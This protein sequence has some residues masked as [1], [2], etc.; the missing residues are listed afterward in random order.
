MRNRRQPEYA[1]ATREWAFQ[2]GY[3]WRCGHRGLWRV[4]LQIHHFCQGSNRERDNLATTAIS[5][6]YCHDREHNHDGIGLLGWLYLKRYY[7][8]EHYDLAEVCRVRS[9]AATAITEIEVYG[10]RERL[11]Q[12]GVKLR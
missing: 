12:A 7:D 2:F 4:N 3:C 1:E 5:C 11:E 6:A 9:R 8:K 10:Q